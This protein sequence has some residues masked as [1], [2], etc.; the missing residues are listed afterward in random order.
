M[1]LFD[2]T[3]FSDSS[4]MWIFVRQ[5]RLQNIVFYFKFLQLERGF[6]ELPS[7]RLGV[8]LSIFGPDGADVWG[9]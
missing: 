9:Q 4:R 2:L 8:A 7:N 5:L 6:V 1:E 3:K